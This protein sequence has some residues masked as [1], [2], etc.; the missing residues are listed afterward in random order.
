MVPLTA[1]EFDAEVFERVRNAFFDMELPRVQL[2]SAFG[3]VV[4][5]EPVLLSALSS[6]SSDTIY[7]IVP[8][9]T[10]GN[11]V[12]CKDFDGILTLMELLPE[13]DSVPGSWRP[14]GFD[15][16]FYDITGVLV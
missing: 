8:V 4:V 2:A 9:G 14:W 12:I 10:I 11:N 3:R 13:E 6:A 5:P 7:C 15:T 1:A 16:Y